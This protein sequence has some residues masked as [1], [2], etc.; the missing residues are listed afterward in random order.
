MD[1]TAGSDN[2]PRN[3]SPLKPDDGKNLSDIEVKIIP[4][5]TDGALAT[6]EKQNMAV[7]GHDHKENNDER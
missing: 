7:T 1:G 2:Q 4:D 5:Q 3:V 6:S